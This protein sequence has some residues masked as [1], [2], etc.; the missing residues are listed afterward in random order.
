MNRI[1][2]DH[3]PNSDNIK[4]ACSIFHRALKYKHASVYSLKVSHSIIILLY[5]TDICI[6]IFSRFANLI[7][8]LAIYNV[9]MNAC[10]KT[11]MR[12]ADFSNCYRGT[13]LFRVTVVSKRRN[14]R[15]TNYSS[16]DLAGKG[17]KRENR[18]CSR[19]GVQFVG[20]FLGSVATTSIVSKSGHERV[21]D[22]HWAGGLAATYIRWRNPERVKGGR[23]RRTR[24]GIWLNRNGRGDIF[25]PA[26]KFG[27]WL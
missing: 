10:L 12:H 11:G 27:A 6:R 4:C 25:K 23:W 13:I 21:R 22:A 17:R 26:T 8:V 18:S 20:G 3:V 19:T 9:G 7:C 16:K 2:N 15:E 5:V 1:E 14:K 24:A